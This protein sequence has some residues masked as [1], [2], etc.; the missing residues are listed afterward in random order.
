MVGQFVSSIG[1]VHGFQVMLIAWNMFRRPQGAFKQ[2]FELG[3]MYEKNTH[4]P[5]CWASPDISTDTQNDVWYQNCTA[6]SDQTARK[7]GL[8]HGT[9]CTTATQ[10]VKNFWINFWK[11]F[12]KSLYV[13]VS[14]GIFCYLNNIFSVFYAQVTGVNKKIILIMIHTWRKTRTWDSN[15]QIKNS[16][17]KIIACIHIRFK[18]SVLVRIEM[19][20]FFIF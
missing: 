20:L 9:D 15:G 6:A 14:T 2:I 10:V 11:I 13:C 19:V 1:S 16:T 12:Q 4:D 3:P 7:E 8:R 18:I 5:V 17:N